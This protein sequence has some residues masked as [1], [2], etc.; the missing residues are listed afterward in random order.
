MFTAKTQRTQREIE[1]ISNPNV[2]A[3]NPNEI[4]SSNEQ[5]KGERHLATDLHR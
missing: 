1:Y 3:Q 5:M 4:Q 2:K